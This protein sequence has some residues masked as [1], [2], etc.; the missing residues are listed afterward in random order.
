MKVQ[1]GILESKGFPTKRI[2]HT[3]FAV[4]SSERWGMLEVTDTL[5]PY[6]VGTKH[7]LG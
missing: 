3:S 1:T 7:A 5:F 6:P 2:R 4:N